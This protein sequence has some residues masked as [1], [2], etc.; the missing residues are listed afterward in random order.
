MKEKK[1]ESSKPFDK[2]SMSDKDMLDLLIELSDTTFYQALLRLWEGEIV[3]AFNMLGSLDPAKDYIKM[4]KAQERR[5]S[6]LFVQHIVDTEKDRRRRIAAGEKVDD[7][8]KDA[9]SY[10]F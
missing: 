3:Q 2:D 10:Q 1:Q 4:A 5:N 9:P 6:M 8:D 7:P